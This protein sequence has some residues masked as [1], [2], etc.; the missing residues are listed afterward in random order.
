[1]FRSFGVF[2]ASFTLAIA[3]VSWANPP[4]AQGQS[5]LKPDVEL[6][7][8]NGSFEFDELDPG[9]DLGRSGI[10]DVSGGDFTIH[11][12]VRFAS[13]VND[14]PCW[15][16]QCDMA[17]AEKIS[18][19]YNSSGWR[20]LKQSDG[21]F[22]FCLG[23]GPANG[24]EQ[25]ASTTVISQTEPVADVW[26]SVVGVKTANQISIYVNGVLEGSKNPGEYFDAS[27][28]PFLVG[29]NRS[30]HS[31]LVGEVGQ[32]Q[33]YR[34]ALSAPHVRALYESSK[35]RFEQGETE[36]GLVAYWPFDG[37][38]TL[39]FSGNHNDGE[40]IGAKQ[41]SDRFGRPNH[42]YLFDGTDDYIAIANSPSLQIG[43]GDYTIAAWIRSNVPFGYGRIFS[44]GSFGCTTGYMMRLGGENVWLENASDGAC[45]VFFGG[46]R[47]VADGAWH[48]VVGVVDR[49][50]GAAIY[51]DGALDAMQMID[52]SAYDLSNDRD[53]TIGVADRMSQE[54]FSGKI[55]DVR[56]YSKALSA[57]EVGTLYNT[58][59]KPPSK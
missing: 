32:V 30:E 43:T 15:G 14:Y 28:A 55:D 11:A 26:Y 9:M 53:P 10:F 34:S 57:L 20:L 47:T 2:E 37:G 36:D 13:L 19:E 25:Q 54:F 35:S 33:L 1:M 49:D 41:T 4:I 12:W 56:I 16:P 6:V 58:S 22:W 31:F 45:H 38:S 42:A 3:L 40:A 21:H 39:D 23:G 17:I 52:T 59:K 48:F 44:K 50:V 51:V 18:G 29:S 8:N 5:V 27:D 24:C 46:K 7:A